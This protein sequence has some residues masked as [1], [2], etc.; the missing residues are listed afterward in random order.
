MATRRNT[1]TQAR[2]SAAPQRRGGGLS[3][4]TVFVVGAAIGAAVLF[5]APKLLKEDGTDS[6]LRPK[7]NADAEPVSMA[8]EQRVADGDGV[9]AKSSDSATAAEPA[10]E[11]TEEG[12]EF[13]F[14]NVL[15]NK[16]VEMTPEQQAALNQAEARRRSQAEASARKKAEA[17]ALAA[18]VAGSQADAGVVVMPDANAPAATL[19]KP[20]AVNVPR[21]A[22][23]TAPKTTL[24]AP[25][26]SAKPATVETKPA[27]T[28]ALP[29]PVAAV[30]PSVKDR[31]VKA[32]ATT[33]AEAPKPKAKAVAA[34]AKN[35]DVTA[36]GKGVAMVMPAASLDPTRTFEKPAVSKTTSAAPAA[37]SASSNSKVLVQAGAFS[38]KGQAE[39]V[40]AKIAMLGLGARVE[41]S[42]NA[43]KSVYR[44]RLGPYAE[45]SS[46]L[47]AAKRKLSG[48]GVNA[49]EVHIN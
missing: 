11:S 17:A 49:M 27:E 45:N 22:S 24:S 39:K 6:F 32:A 31:P 21:A 4:S 34:Y 5:G 40:K 44:V 42:T 14:Y 48:G 46:E 15:A 47:S 30:T 16:E 2:R 9:V 7:P 19:P 18:S 37:A 13:D 25:A 38:D 28:K 43:G 23:T 41:S 36:V 20:V 26:A 12:T 35:P 3:P 1:K 33:V 29:K 10:A 8:T